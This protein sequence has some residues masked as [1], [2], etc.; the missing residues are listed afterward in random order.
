M[1]TSNFRILKIIDSYIIKELTG[2]FIFGIAAF[3]CILAGSTVLFPL[4]GTAVSYNIPYTQVVQ[5]FIYKLPNVIVFSFPM[6]MLLASILAFSRLSSDNELMAFRSTGISF[7]RLV[8]PVIITGFFVSLFAIWFN[9][10]VVPVSSNSAENL[11]R[12][13]TKKQLPNIKKNINFTEYDPITKDPV[14]TINVSEVKDEKMKNITIAEYDKGK[15]AR[16]V[17]AGSG[18]WLES[19]QWIFFNGVMHSFPATDITQVTVIEFEKEYIDIKINP[20]DLTKRKKNIEEMTRKE[21]KARII[22]KKNT[23]AD[24]IKDIV[25]YHLKYSVPFACLIFSIL[26]TSVGLKPNRSSSALGLGI[27]LIVILIYYILLGIST[28]L[29]LAHA[30]PA[31]LAAWLPNI[32]IGMAGFFLLHKIAQQ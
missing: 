32:V 16:I 4:I 23:G 10:S 26:G 2:P 5:L 3:S 12:S 30:I 29:G 21:L 25:N 9:E 11:M 27:S 17:R 8:I 18:K 1:I 13:F 6:S 20:V 31:L 14:R 19:G 28:G 15:L 22:M 24:P 7:R